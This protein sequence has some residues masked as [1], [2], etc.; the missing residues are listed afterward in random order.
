VELRA[1][2]DEADN[3]DLAER[4]QEVGAH[5]VYGVVGYKTH[6]KMMLVVRREESGLRNYVH[7]ATG[8]YHLRTSRLY[9]DYGLMTA[10]AEICKDVHTV[11]HQLTSLGKAAKMHRLLQSPFTMASGMHAK[12]EREMNNAASGKPARI[13]AKM[14]AL[15]EPEMIARLYA[16]SQAGVKIQLVVRGMCSLRPGV[17][18]LS[19]NIEVHSVIGRFLE[20]HRT[21]YFENGGDPEVYLSSADWMERNLFR[22]VEIAFPLLD[23]KL[24][25][26]VTEQLMAYVDDRAQSWALREDGRYERLGGGGKGV[27][28]RLLETLTDYE[29][30]EAKVVSQMLKPRG[31]SR[32]KK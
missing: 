23:K 4:L 15:V 14:N 3:I 18:G 17:K 12:I 20:H 27:Q 10:D 13:V 32:R 6:A 7:L 8:N 16:A 1:R 25:A 11:F 9:T 5:V 22:R 21:F 28:T 19:E 31:G 2:F 26:E 29:L 24:R 30:P